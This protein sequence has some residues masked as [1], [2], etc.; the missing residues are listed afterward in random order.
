[1]SPAEPHWSSVWTSREE[2]DVSWHQPVPQRS[3]D[4]IS[5][6]AP[7]PAAH[8]VDVGGGASSLVDRLLDAGYRH[9][10]VVDI[11]R[12][13]LDRAQARLGDRAD[14]VTWIR[15]DATRLELDHP[16]DLWHDRALF[17]FLTDETDR[18]RYV[19]TAAT[20]L[21]DRGHAIIATFG[22]NGPTHCSGLTVHRYDAHELAETFAPA[23]FTLAGHHDEI[24]RT[25]GG[26][27]Q[28]FV[29]A[30]LQRR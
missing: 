5:D 20:Q 26:V 15:A 2:E 3:L 4:L 24:H 14:L 21:A 6:A 9:V 17:H 1:V 11:A 16:A 29:Y 8:I 19:R 12:A 7:D 23:G 18:D 27:T 25:P 28:E 13:A 22:P 10:T 30:V